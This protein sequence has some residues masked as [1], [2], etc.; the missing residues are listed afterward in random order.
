MTR[1]KETGLGVICGF[2]RQ[3]ALGWR[4]GMMINPVLTGRPSLD[5]AAQFYRHFSDA[6]DNRLWCRDRINRQEDWYG[7]G[8]GNA[9]DVPVSVFGAIA[10][11][12]GGGS[13]WSSISANQWEMDVACPHPVRV[14]RDG[15][16]VLVD[17]PVAIGAG[18]SVAA[19]LGDFC[20]HSFTA[21]AG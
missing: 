14:Q 6:D 2:H 7:N 1:F 18:D 12:N 5:P 15:L 16:L 8:T 21:A 10:G 11:D 3:A 20:H 13:P 9:A 17:P 19:K 4:K